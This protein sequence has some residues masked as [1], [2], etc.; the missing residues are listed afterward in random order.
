MA[1][2]PP[3]L[4]SFSNFLYVCLYQCSPRLPFRGNACFPQKLVACI[5]MLW[6]CPPFACGDLL[7]GLEILKS[8]LA[9]SF[10]KQILERVC[11]LNGKWAITN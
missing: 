2:K 1:G 7:G 4:P 11:W 9:P 3:W 8:Y 6:K 5:G 10:G